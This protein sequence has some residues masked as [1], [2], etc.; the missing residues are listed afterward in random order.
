MRWRV[1]TV[2]EYTRT[3]TRTV[4]LYTVRYRGEGFR[5]PWAVFRRGE[6]CYSAGNETDAVNWARWQMGWS[7][8]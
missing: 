3:E 6:V 2:S 5:K 1:S 8:K 7:D 4:G